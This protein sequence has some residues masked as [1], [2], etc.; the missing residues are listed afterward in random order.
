M[1][2]CS[3]SVVSS[4]KIDSSGSTGLYRICPCRK[5]FMS[6]APRKVFAFSFAS[7][8]GSHHFFLRPQ[9]STDLLLKY[10]L[11]T[12]SGRAAPERHRVAR[13]VRRSRGPDTG[14]SVIHE[15]YA[16]RGRARVA[17]VPPSMYTTAESCVTEHRFD[18][19]L[20]C[21]EVLHASDGAHAE[22]AAEYDFYFSRSAAGRYDF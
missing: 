7:G 9:A 13:T 18:D 20:F 17:V 16:P 19:E 1:S 22:Q 10:P 12:G 8:G 4:R 11:Y 5:A 21:S 14:S 2:S 3:F 6:G 15:L